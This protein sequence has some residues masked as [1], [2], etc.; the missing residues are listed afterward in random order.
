MNQYLGTTGDWRRFWRHTLICG[1]LIAATHAHAQTLLSMPQNLLFQADR[2]M[3]TS[4]NPPSEEECDENNCGCNTTVHS[5]TPG[6]NS[7]PG[8]YR[9]NGVTSLS[10]NPGAGANSIGVLNGTAYREVIDL[11]ANAGV[12]EHR[13]AFIRAHNTAGDNLNSVLGDGGAWRHGYQWNVNALALDAA[14][15]TPDGQH[16]AYTLVYETE[17]P[18]DEL[19]GQ[20]E[21]YYG[22]PPSE[23]ELL[24]YAYANIGVVD[25]QGRTNVTLRHGLNE[26]Q[27]GFE[28]INWGFTNYAI[29]TDAGWRYE[30]E[31]RAHTNSVVEQQLALARFI[32]AHGVV[33]TVECDDAR[34]VTKVTEPAGRWLSITYHTNGYV[35]RVDLSDS[36][37]VTYQYSTVTTNSLDYHLLTGASYQDGTSAAYQYYDVVPHLLATMDDPKLSGPAARIKYVYAEIDGEHVVGREEHPVTGEMIVQMNAVHDY[38]GE[39]SVDL[40]FITNSVGDVLLYLAAG[41]E[42]GEA[43][44]KSY[45]SVYYDANTNIVQRYWETSQN[46]EDSEVTTDALGRQKRDVFVNRRLIRQELTDPQFNVIRSNLWQRNAAGFVTNKVDVAGRSTVYDRDASN[47]VVRVT[48]PDG[49]TEG[50]AY[51]AWSQIVSGTNQLGEVSTYNYDSTGRL[52]AIISPEGYVTGFAYDTYDRLIRRTNALGHVTQ[53]DYYTSGRVR[54]ITHPDQTT[55]SFGY[56]DYGHQTEHTNEVGRV[57]YTTYDSFLNVASRTDE[58]GRV[59]TYSYDVAPGCCGGGNGGGGGGRVSRVTTPSGKVTDFV[60]DEFSRKIMEIENVG[61]SSVSTNFFHYDLLGRLTNRVDVFG[62]EWKTEYNVFDQP[63]RQTNPL[64]QTTTNL[65]SIDGLLLTNLT[66]RGAQTVHQYD[67]MRRITNT[68][69]PDGG[70][71]SR[72]YHADGR[73]DRIAGT[74]VHGRRYEYGH[75]TNGIFVKEIK[76]LANGNDSGEWIKRYRDAAGNDVKTFHADGATETREY[77]SRNRLVKSVDADGVTQLFTYTADGHPHLRAVDMNHNDAIDLVGTDRV[78]ANLLSLMTNGNI[79][80]GP[81]IVVETWVWDTLNQNTSNR[82]AYVETSLDGMEVAQ[83]HYGLTNI[84]R[85]PPCSACGS[86]TNIAPDGSYTLSVYEDGRLMSTTRYDSQDNQLGS[87][88]ITYDAL[89]RRQTVADA[90]TGTNSYLYNDDLGWSS[91]TPP[92]PAG[93]IPPQT[94]TTYTDLMGRPWRVV[95]PDGASVTNEYH[96]TGELKKTYGAR[97]YPVEYTYDHAGRVKTMKTW[98]DFAADSGTATTSWS[99]DAQRGWLTQKQYDDGDGPAYTYHPTGKLNTRTWE[100]GVTTTYAYNNAGDLAS[101]NYSDTTPDIA[102]THDRL[103]RQSTITLGTNTTTKTY[104]DSGSLVTESYTGGPLNGITV[105]NT[106][107]PLSRRSRLETTLNSQLMTSLSYTHDHASRLE[108][109]SDGPNTATYTYLANSPL[110]SQIAFTQN[111]TNR[112]TTTKSYDDLNRLTSITHADSQL[113]TLASYNYGYNSANQRTNV[114]HSDGSHW[115]YGYDV[116]GQVITAKKRNLDDLLFPGLQY[117][118]DYDDI[119]NRTQTRTGG[120]ANGQNLRTNNYTANALNQYTTRDVG[121][122]IEVHGRAATN[123][124]VTVNNQ[125]TERVGPFF[126][127]ELNPD[128]SAAVINQGITNVAVLKNAGPGGVDIVNEETG[129]QLLRQNPETFVHDADG[130]LVTDGLWHYV[131]NGENRLIQMTSRTNVPA[132]ER[133]KLEFTYDHQGRRITKTVHLWNQ[134]TN[135]YLPTATNLFVYDGWNLIATLN[136]SPSQSSTLHQSYAWGLDLSGSEQGA[137]GVGGYLFFTQHS[138]PQPST[139]YAGHDGNGNVMLLASSDTV[140]ITAQ[141]EYSPF[142]KVIRASGDMAEA[143]P[144]RFSGKYQDAESGYY[145]YGYRFYNPD[146]GRWLNRDPIEEEGHIELKVANEYGSIIDY[147]LSDE[148]NLDELNEYGFVLNNPIG[149]VDPRGEAFWV[150]IIVIGCKIAVKSYKAYKTIVKARKAL[151]KT[152]NA[153]WVAYKAACNVGCSGSTC[154]AASAGYKAAQA[155]V[156]G[157]SLYISMGCDKVGRGY[158]KKGKKNPHWKADKQKHENELKNAKQALKNCNAKKKNAC[159][160]KNAQGC[161]QKNCQPWA[162]Q[163]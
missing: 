71:I 27:L 107:D 39:E 43:T 160:G 66:I 47:R 163:A 7:V 98:K 144:I 147:L 14:V 23:T 57:S 72:T 146:T 123:A 111:G 131:W 68:V 153:V 70:V 50:F 94:T 89:G 134:T 74:A 42:G 108:S 93:G 149:Y 59:T 3:G 139:H 60:Y 56:N 121:P 112:M 15:T 73:P 16:T 19:P 102:Y 152:C 117:E 18:A 58:F 115:N 126:R 22:H 120:D 140:T 8:T 150:P 85:T 158:G 128:N 141:Y 63:H 81:A 137:G 103:G 64:G 118:F 84:T 162:P 35:S 53:Y 32:D 156:S 75:D 106:F 5:P 119:G 48:H 33:Y 4:V 46:G 24:A 28:M 69:N 97:T 9:N 26:I 49:A 2:C 34:R 78:T 6:I 132:G 52:E 30:F 21:D 40:V 13:L 88:T 145:Y 76:L 10:G 61:Q 25:A 87:Q 148:M 105:T 55:E 45:V 151:A 157:R 11:Q 86:T 79:V 54:T 83:A 116:L 113:S 41:D 122:H 127:K 100:R 1:L 135:A 143:N 36:R 12:G 110:V 138:T 91:V 159:S 129:S 109:V 65:F 125:S 161:P 67:A 136:S 17:D 92:A 154:Q 90:R 96:L 130:N 99:Y 80:S 104:T 114:V 133:K 29:L 77:D 20:A 44:K 82:V 51:N 101:I 95:Q 62:G 31:K 37:F 155:C 142:G 38:S 124:T